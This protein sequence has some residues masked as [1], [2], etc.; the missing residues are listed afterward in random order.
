MYIP[1]PYLENR[2]EVL[3]NAMRARAFGSLI[4]AGD[5]GIRVSHL[6]FGVTGTSDAPI[7]IAH[8]ARANPQWRDITAQTEA[9]ATFLLEDGYISPSWYP[10]KTETGKVVPTWNYVAVEARGPVELIE[11]GPGLLALID[12]LTFNHEN[13]RAKPWTT[14]DA[15]ADYMDAL[16]RGIVGVR[17]TVRELTGAWKLDQKKPAHDRLG[18]ARGLTEEANNPSLAALIRATLPATDLLE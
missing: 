14:K 6:P 16:M 13:P 15:P 10:T 7:L 3:L 1:L 11:T 4:T 18:A 5:S 12:E 9:V 2:R 8:L 17:L